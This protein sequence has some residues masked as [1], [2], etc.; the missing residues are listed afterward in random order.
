MLLLKYLTCTVELTW[1]RSLQV[2]FG[3]VVQKT[4]IQSSYYTRRFATFV[5][6]SVISSQYLQICFPAFPDET[7]AGLHLDDMEIAPDFF[8]YFEAAADLMDKDKWVLIYLCYSWSLAQELLLS[9]F[10]L[11]L[12]AGLSWLF[13]HGMIMDKSSS[14]TIHVSSGLPLCISL[15]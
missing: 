1:F 8:E 2:G 5:N 9:W 3:W 15:W 7:K 13:H 11:F 14:F 12:I 6:Y 10:H 4:Q